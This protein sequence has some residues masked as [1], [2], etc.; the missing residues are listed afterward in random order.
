[1]KMMV[2]EP[3]REWEGEVGLRL[4]EMERW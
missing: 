4:V 3:T 2:R 1:M